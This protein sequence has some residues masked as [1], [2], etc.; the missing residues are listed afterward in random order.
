MTTFLILIFSASPP[1]LA[2]SLPC[3]DDFATI[4]TRYKVTHIQRRH[5]PG[6]KRCRTH[7]KYS[8]LAPTFTILYIADLHNPRASRNPPAFLYLMMDCA[9][10]RLSFY[11]PTP[12]CAQIASKTAKPFT[13]SLPSH[14]AALRIPEL[15]RY[16]TTRHPVPYGPLPQAKRKTLSPAPSPLA[17]MSW[18]A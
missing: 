16:Q 18:L 6:F 7:S 15:T 9:E 12:S 17:N 5:I 8:Y 4:P 11:N 1:M 3:F 14:E 2:L 10:I 13:A